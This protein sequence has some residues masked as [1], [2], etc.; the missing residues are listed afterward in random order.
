[1]IT[2]IITTYKREPGMLKRAI[3]SVISQTFTDWELIIVDDS[4]ADYAFSDDVRDMVL[5]LKGNISYVR[6]ER[7]YGAN[8]AR[9]TGL[10][11]AKGE[12]IAYLDD[13][14]EF[15]PEKLEK[16]LARFTNENIAMVYCGRMMVHDDTG[17]EETAK[18]VFI[19][20]SIYDDL[21]REN[22]VGSCSFPLVR[23]KALEDAGGFD[24]G[25]KSCQDWDMWLTIAQ[26]HDAAFVP[27]P[28]V[29]YHVHTG[30]HITG[31]ITRRIQGLEGICRKHPAKS[32]YIRCKRLSALSEMYR[33]NGEYMKSF[34]LWLRAL[35]LQ[36]FRLWAHIKGE[37]R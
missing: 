9:N 33:E 13:D 3:D 32:R 18:S 27:E 28:L 25:M 5:G 30:E 10:K 15:M 23:R 37:K 29:R 24:E 8:R 17:T 1:M 6:H 34:M 11:L 12:Y 7:N 26:K 16:Q 19:E 35:P 31:S 36:P 20:G 2:V 22:F 21:M 14:D 4:P